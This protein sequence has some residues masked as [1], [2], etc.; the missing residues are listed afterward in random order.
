MTTHRRTVTMGW[1]WLAVCGLLIYMGGLGLYRMLIPAKDDTDPPGMIL[2][3]DA[4][5]GCQ[6]LVEPRGG[7]T[8]RVDDAGRH[9][10]E[11]TPE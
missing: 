7:I 4:L 6:Y 11:R 9:I 2:R 1:V 8:P 5:T 3:V 10:C